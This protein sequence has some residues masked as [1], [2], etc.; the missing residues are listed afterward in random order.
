MDN[1]EITILDLY[2]GAYLLCRGF[3]LRKVTVVGTNG[4]KLCTFSFDESAK[5]AQDEYR[6]GRATANVALLKYTMN[7]LKDEMFKKIRAIERKEREL[8]SALPKQRRQKRAIR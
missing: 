6:Q 1:P 7:N 4:N 5:Q 3:Q 8:C 2:E